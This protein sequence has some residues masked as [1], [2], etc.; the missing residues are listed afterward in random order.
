MTELQNSSCGR[1][2][3]G[4]SA[5]LSGRGRNCCPSRIPTCGICPDNPC[6]LRQGPASCGTAGTCTG[7]GGIEGLGIGYPGNA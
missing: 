2:C 1:S 3:H 5:N 7:S 4:L 6:I